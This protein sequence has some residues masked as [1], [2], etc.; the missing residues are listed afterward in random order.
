MPYFSKDF[1]EFFKELAANN[2]KEWF[3]KNRKRYDREVKEPFK[4]FI[5]DMLVRMKKEDP[6]ITQEP[7][8]AIFRINRDIRFSK[9]KT[10]YKVQ[11]S[12][13]ISP[14]GKKDFAS[15]GLYLELTPEHVRVY[16]G[17]YMPDKDQLYNI[18]N[19][20]V[21]QPKEFKEAINDK[22]FKSGYGEIRGEKNKQIPK[23]FR[24]AAEDQPLI[25]NKQFYYF[26]EMK[27]EVILKENLPDLIMERY[28]DSKPVRTFFARA[29]NG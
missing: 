6:N 23:E 29:I 2:H 12:A 19:F 5:S 22:K 21:N 17:V 1:I 15:P 11:M 26:T 8:D 3:D 13:A 18:R 16:G 9:D 7:K 20:I 24:E 4:V 28:R 27:P 10:P 25:Y 14:G